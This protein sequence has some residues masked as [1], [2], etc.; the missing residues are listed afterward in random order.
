MGYHKPKLILLRHSGANTNDNNRNDNNDDGV[1]DDNDD[2]GDE[3]NSGN[4][5]EDRSA[6]KSVHVFAA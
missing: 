6:T 4:E 1:N 2:N 5:D 3:E